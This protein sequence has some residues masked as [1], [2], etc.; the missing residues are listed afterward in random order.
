MVVHVV[1]VLALVQGAADTLTVAE[2]VRLA[3]AANPSLAAARLM[4]DA[5]AE[6]VGPAGA[7]PD[8]ELTLGLVNR[9]LYGFG[10][11]EPMTM[12]VVGVSQVVPWPA[13]L[14]AQRERARRL[15]AAGSFD[16]DETEA[17]LVRRV[18]AAHH[19]LAF[20]DRSLSVMER[21][22]GL[23]RQ[24]E[25][26]ARVRYAVGDGLQ[27]DVLRA[28]VAV[29]QMT[30]EI[31]AMQAER[32]A[33][34]ARLNTL[35]GRDAT[36]PIAALSFVTP[37]ADLPDMDSLLALAV[38]QRP[39][40]AAADERVRAAAAAERAARAELLPDLMLSVSYGQR[41]RFDDMVSLMVGISL[42]LWAGSRALPMR[43]ETAAIRAGAEADALA[44]RNETYAELTELHAA[45]VRAHALMELYDDDILPQARAAVA[46]A[47]AAY[48]VGRVEF[49]TLLENE[50]AVNTY[51]IARLR[52]DVHYH[53]A[54]AGI[55]ALTGFMGG[56]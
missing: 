53:H 16:A 31:V 3:R 20:V 6:R 28:Q 36:V 23:L 15:A 34:A 18:E 2:A 55:E 47:L 38:R 50:M 13:R 22:S 33:T 52:F 51:E 21:T 1:A 32:R 11:T 7:L 25:E 45:A 49:A 24:F 42:P 56:H 39:A 46:S 14:G 26:V 9:P 30:Q 12:N 4:A 27:Q 35:L 19:D 54:L 43:R 40:L 8:P 44:L 41:P 10:V 17:T 5:A 48:R 29:G 37:H